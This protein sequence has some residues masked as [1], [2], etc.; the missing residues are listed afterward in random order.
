MAL[1]NNEHGAHI[2]LDQ[3]FQTDPAHIAVDDSGD[4]VAV[5]E[6]NVTHIIDTNTGHVRARLEG[7]AAPV[8]AA[9]FRK[10]DDGRLCVISI[11]EDR[12]FLVFDLTRQCLVY[13]S[14]IISA[15]PFISLAM[16]PRGTR[17][18]IGSADGKVRVYDMTKDDHRMLRVLDVGALTGL[19]DRPWQQKRAAKD[20]LVG[21]E[22]TETVVITSE[23]AWKK[24]LD[25]QLDLAAEDVQ[26]M[27]LSDKAS[28]QCPIVALS[29]AAPGNTEHDAQADADEGDDNGD[30]HGE[31]SHGMI[32]GMSAAGGQRP[33]PNEWAH[34]PLRA[35]SLIVGTPSCLLCT[36][37]VNA[38]VTCAL[39][40]E[41]SDPPDAS[42]TAVKAWQVAPVGTVG[43]MS[44]THNANS[45]E[46]RIASAAAFVPCISIVSFQLQSAAAHV[47]AQSSGAQA[48]FTVTGRADI[49][50][51][52]F[53][54][55]AP[56]A[57][58]ILC[59][60]RGRSDSD[61]DSSSTTTSTKG[62]Q[63][64]GGRSMSG[65]RQSLESIMRT[66]GVAGNQ[67][68][69]FHSKIRSSNYGATRPVPLFGASA[70]TKGG[71]KP[72]L[73][74]SA[75][76]GSKSSNNS[77][78]SGLLSKEYPM[79]SDLPRFRQK[80]VDAHPALHSAPI[81]RICFSGD[82]SRLATASS[83]K[84][85]CVVRT[86][87][88]KYAAE[89]SFL[90]GHSAPVN[91]VAWSRDSS[92]IIT[93]AS[94]RSVRVWSPDKSTCESLL[95]MDRRKNQYRAGVTK[96]EEDANPPYACDVRDA[97]FFYMDRCLCVHV[98]MYVCICVCVYVYKYMMCAM[99]AS[100]M[101]T[102]C[103]CVLICM[104]VCIYV[105]VCMC[106][107]I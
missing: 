23:P 43:C 77:G 7:H 59:E 70:G 78:A 88:R 56:P 12:R 99:Q 97:S 1:Q 32:I 30:H 60:E 34:M 13:Q 74:K 66:S 57:G 90:T 42:G 20:D 17:C 81:R 104:Y 83:D 63:T 6:Q 101:W 93:T 40:L 25:A 68:V 18:A 22:S 71:K 36:N 46:I 45:R 16:D 29:F 2:L 14:A 53:P 84:T 96:Q 44:I 103:L 86:P 41:S 19:H 58:S 52:V 62:K 38:E 61:T 51:S 33:R 79:A 102:R 21:S 27:S 69:T 15:S 10:S 31:D 9:E 95:V 11:S 35:L 64:M 26:A 82:A 85:V 49:V 55:H 67:P 91:T 65:G 47:H 87:L 24:M 89:G 106:I 54:S 75:S 37:M 3:A 100:F 5:C 107:N 98:C 50:A 76:T 80:D 72:P 92:M 94:D 73:V 4:K 105:C 48:L 8:T 28:R 39:W